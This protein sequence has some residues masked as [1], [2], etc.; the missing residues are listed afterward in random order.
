MQRSYIT[1][2]GEIAQ[3]TVNTHAGDDYRYSMTLHRVPGP[4]AL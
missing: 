3:V 2:E 4:G 1:S